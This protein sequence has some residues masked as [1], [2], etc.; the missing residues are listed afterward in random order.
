MKPWS[1]AGTLSGV[2]SPVKQIL[3]YQNHLD[4]GLMAHLWKLSGFKQPSVHA[5]RKATLHE[6]ED[7]I[8]KSEIE[9]D[10]D[11]LEKYKPDPQAQLDIVFEKQGKVFA[12]YHLDCRHPGR[13]HRHWWRYRVESGKPVIDAVF[14]VAIM[15]L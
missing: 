11:R 3:F 5:P 14:P 2:E 4:N 12:Y 15:S 7:T 13:I 1:A 6:I 8:R 9:V 10:A